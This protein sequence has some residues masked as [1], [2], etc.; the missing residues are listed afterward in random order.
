MVVIIYPYK[1]PNQSYLAALVV[2]G[3]GT[4]SL[5]VMLWAEIKSFKGEVAWLD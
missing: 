1:G 5:I 4:L 3:V 2:S